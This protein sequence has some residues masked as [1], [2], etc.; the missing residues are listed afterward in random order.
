[1][2]K[3]LEKIK[4]LRFHTNMS[5]VNVTKT[6]KLINVQAYLLVCKRGAETDLDVQ[7]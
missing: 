4:I 5:Y 6:D 3:H 2:Q 7:I 1:M